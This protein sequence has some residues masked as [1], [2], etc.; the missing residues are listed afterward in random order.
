[1]IIMI[2]SGVEAKV[3]GN[4]IPAGGKKNLRMKIVPCAHGQHTIKLK[5]KLEIGKSLLWYDQ[6]SI[7]NDRSVNG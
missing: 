3:N 6:F 5:Y 2:Q 7:D 4:S 1:M